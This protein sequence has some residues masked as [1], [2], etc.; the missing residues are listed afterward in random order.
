MTAVVRTE[1]CWPGHFICATKCG[2]RRNTLLQ[3]GDVAIVV[4]T[5]GAMRD[6]PGSDIGEIG[7][8][9]ACETMAFHAHQNGPYL[10][11]DV[12]RQVAFDA[13]WGISMKDY[14]REDFQG[15]LRTDEMHEAV[16]AEIT[17]RLAAG[18]TFPSEEE[19][20]DA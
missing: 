9:R 12:L 1:R 14:N 16:V 13:P 3:C 15:D 20:E 5:V 18:E 8:H 4:S 10:D 7:Y 11:A 6:R 17:A 2:L 19:S